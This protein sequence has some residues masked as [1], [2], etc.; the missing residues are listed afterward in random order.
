MWA[1]LAGFVG[2]M[3]AVDTIMAFAIRFLP[4]EVSET[5]EPMMG[6]LLERRSGGMLTIG[7][8]GTLWAASAGVE[9]FRYALNRAWRTLA[10]RSF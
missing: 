8:V 1:P 9:A 10:G 3:E 6:E 4:R 5:L 7:V 2:D